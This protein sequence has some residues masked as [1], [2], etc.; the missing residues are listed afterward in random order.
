MYYFT[1]TCIGLPVDVFVY[2]YMYSFTSTCFCLPVDVFVRSFV[3]LLS[4]SG[5]FFSQLLRSFIRSY[6]LN[7]NL[8]IIIQMLSLDRSYIV[9]SICNP[10]RYLFVFGVEDI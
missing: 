7:I 9:P 10:F 2:Q 5:F 1:N 8:N 4:D 3:F 6:I